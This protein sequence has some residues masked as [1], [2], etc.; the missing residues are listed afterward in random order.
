M[1]EPGTREGLFD[2]PPFSAL[3]EAVRGELA[4]LVRLERHG[5]GEVIVSEGGIADDLLLLVSG[6]VSVYQAG[7]LTRVA[8]APDNLGLL[9]V[10]E[11]GRRSATLRSFGVCEIGRLSRDDLWRLVHEYPELGTRLILHLG[12]ELRRLYDREE[13]WLSHL[14]DFFD[15]PNA[16]MVPGPYQAE[17][18]EMVLLVMESDPERLASLR[19][20]A[21]R[22]I[23]G[24]EHVYFLTF[25]F[26]ERIVTTH[27]RGRGKSFSYD[28]T[29]PFL[30]CLGPRLSPGLFT[31]ELYPDNY[32]AIAIGRELYGLPKRFGLT[33]RRG[34]EVE[35][36]LGQRLVL[37]GRWEGEEPCSVAEFTQGV[38]T[39]V[40]APETLAWL[41]GAANRGLHALAR[42]RDHQRLPVSLPLWVRQQVPQ[43]RLEEP[44]EWAKDRLLEV[45][46]RLSAV[47]QLT[48]LHGPEVRVYEDGHFLAGRCLGGWGLRAAFGF[49][50]V[51]V[52]RDYLEK[53]GK[54][55]WVRRLLGG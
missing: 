15:P 40:G 16:R 49:D 4:H 3:D 26:F 42:R 21:L 17:P 20:P 48:R 29:T 5:D 39:C 53:R 1:T 28:E 44:G 7:K 2:S 46:F 12:G 32:L 33:N 24:L 41:A 52:C 34:R 25:N 43:V 47:D 13:Q 9:S 45:P 19:P 54:R 27:P 36:L 50:K 51:A 31:P 30:P 8:R 22:A 37:R 10:L 6:E 18:Y 38:A 11:R 35:L 23:P 55:A 14:E